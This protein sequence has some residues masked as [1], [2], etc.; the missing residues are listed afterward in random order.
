MRL[1][2]EAEDAE[3]SAEL[4]MSITIRE[5]GT[6]RLEIGIQQKELEF[7]KMKNWVQAQ[8]EIEEK[9]YW[10]IDVSAGRGDG[11]E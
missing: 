11:N 7:D 8:Q 1:M 10:T 9:L 6:A 4:K 2:F 3:R 5:W